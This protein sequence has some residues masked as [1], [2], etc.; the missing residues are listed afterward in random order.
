M[1]G[2]AAVGAGD[3]TDSVRAAEQ[4][5]FPQRE[6]DHLLPHEVSREKDIWYI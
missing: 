6:C 1:Q 2:P 4:C 3:G 5:G